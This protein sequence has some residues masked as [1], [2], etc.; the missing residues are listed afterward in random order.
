MKENPLDIWFNIIMC[1]LV[2]FVLLLLIY[3]VPMIFIETNSKISFCKENGFDNLYDFKKCSNS[4]TITQENIKCEWEF[5]KVNN[6]KFIGE[7]K[8]ISMIEEVQK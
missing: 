3:S 2:L 1:V 5:Y 6:C 8:I 7:R 4:T